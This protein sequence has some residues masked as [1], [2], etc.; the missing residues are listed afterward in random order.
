MRPTRSS[1]GR[2]ELRPPV[3]VCGR[4][5]YEIRFPESEISKVQV[6][7]LH[8]VNRDLYSPLSTTFKL[9]VFGNREGLCQF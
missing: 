1:L 8:I 4:A 6:R 7:G 5:E 2:P 9:V 3:G